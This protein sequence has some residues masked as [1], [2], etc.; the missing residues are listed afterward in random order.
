M[1][2]TRLLTI[3]ISLVMF[4]FSTFKSY[5]QCPD[6]THPINKS[7]VKKYKKNYN[8]LVGM[9]AKFAMRQ[10]SAT[11]EELECLLKTSD[12]IKFI[13]ASYSAFNAKSM[14]TIVE[15]FYQGNYNYFDLDE[16]FSSV[17]GGKKHI[18]FNK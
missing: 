2:N 5:S 3:A 17:K 1:K 14:I 13:A 18:S 9:H 15:L 4:C 6:M 11:K 12:K 7:D 8:I 16:L 10:I